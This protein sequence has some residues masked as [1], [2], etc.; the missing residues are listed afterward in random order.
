MKDKGEILNGIV[1]D[2]SQ[3]MERKLEYNSLVIAQFKGLPGHEGRVKKLEND[4]IE[5][6]KAIMLMRR[7]EG[8]WA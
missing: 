6:G 2:A 5:I 1:S 4:N 3:I 7:N 8:C